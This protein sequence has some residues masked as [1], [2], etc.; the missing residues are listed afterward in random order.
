MLARQREQAGAAALA[1]ASY[2]Q[3]GEV[4]RSRYANAKAAELFA[5]GL[6]LLE[7]CDHA[8]ED[9]RL[10]ALHHHGDVCTPSAATSTPTGRSSRC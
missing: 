10:K 2:V 7:Q 8:D 1:A 3:A 5:K 9:L 6:K 4:A